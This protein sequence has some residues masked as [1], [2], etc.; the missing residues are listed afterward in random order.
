MKPA[1]LPMRSSARKIPM[2]TGAA[3]IAICSI[4]MLGAAAEDKERVNIGRVVSEAELAAWDI[5]VTPDGTG[6]PP[7][8]GS[9]RQ[10]KAIYDAKCLACHGAEGRGHPMDPLAGGH[11]TLTSATPIKTIGSYWPYATTVFDY[12][13]R[14]M[15]LD[16]PQS[17]SA[18]EVYS[19]T[20]YL[21]HLNGIVGA[22]ATID[23]KTLPKVRMPNLRAFRPDPRPDVTN[24]A[25]ERDCQ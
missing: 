21:L 6:L 9:V 23:A 19:V 10:G 3:A 14:A 24:S 25:C 18:N 1:T 20:A 8:R 16:K 11:S 12:V 17:L 4:A 5:D 22:D 15:P 2:V 13:R 7:G